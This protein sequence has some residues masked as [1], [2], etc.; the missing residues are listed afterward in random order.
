MPRAKQPKK[1][2]VRRTCEACG[3]DI[4]V[5]GSGELRVHTDPKTKEHCPGGRQP[6]DSGTE[7]KAKRYLVEGRV[8]VLSVGLGSATIEVQGSQP[9]PYEVVYFQ[10]T[11]SCNCEAQVWHCAHVA[12]AY[13]VVDPART[14]VSEPDVITPTTVLPVAGDAEVVES[15]EDELSRALAASLEAVNRDPFAHKQQEPVP[16]LEGWTQRADGVQE[17]KVTSEPS[18]P[19]PEQMPE[20]EDRDAPPVVDPLSLLSD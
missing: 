11:W 12:A 1:E 14:R 3:Q 9:D 7:E 20:G 15:P 16:Q 4:Q 8:K 2:V 6:K 18:N 17:A 10:G 19:A 5:V 13:L